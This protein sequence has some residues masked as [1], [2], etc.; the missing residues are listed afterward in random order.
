M[1][2][3]GRCVIKEGKKCHKSKLFREILPNLAPGHLFMLGRLAVP[4]IIYVGPAGSPEN[5]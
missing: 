3:V 2:L 1:P 4:K 5:T